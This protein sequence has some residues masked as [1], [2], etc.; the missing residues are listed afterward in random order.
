MS[1]S[2]SVSEYLKT[3]K[4]FKLCFGFPAMLHTLSKA[5]EKNQLSKINLKEIVNNNQL[6]DEMELYCHNY[7][8]KAKQKHEKGN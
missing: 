7:I 8:R 6:F 4:N 1:G 2:H 3:D 5:L